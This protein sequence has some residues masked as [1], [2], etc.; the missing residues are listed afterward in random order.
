[1]SG[2]GSCTS[3][4]SKCQGGP[5]TA[6]LPTD[7]PLLVW[8]GECA[9]CRRWV[10]RLHAVAGDRIGFAP[11]QEAAHH[12]PHISQH[13]FESAIHLIEPDGTYTSG[14]EAMFATM[15]RLGLRTWPA[16]FYRTLAPFRAVSDT[17][18]RFTTRHRKAADIACRLALGRVEVP[19]TLLL[20]RRVFLRLLGLIYLIAFL[21]FGNQAM[22][23]IGSHGLRPADAL[24][25]QVAEGS[26]S[27]WNFP[28]LQWL[29]GD[30]VLWATWVIGAVAS[31]LLM[32]GIVPLLTSLVCWAMYLSLVTVG[33]VFLQYQWDNLLLECGL[34]AILWAPLTWRL[35]SPLARRPSRLVHWLLVL[36]LARLVFFGGLAKLQSGDPTWTDC[37]ALS[38]YFWTQPLP[39]WPAWI[40][41]S[42]PA[43]ILKLACVGI[44]ILEL[45]APLLLFL[46]RVPR[47]IGA[48]LIA[49]L[50]LGIAA[51]GNYGFFNWLA[52]VLCLSMLDDGVLLMLWPPAAR[53]RIAVG[54][55][56]APGLL[57]RWG[58]R[59]V[60]AVLLLLVLV[61]IREQV[62]VSRVGQPIASLQQAVR[63]WRPVGHYGLFATM[64]KTR[65]E[66]NIEWRDAEGT[67]HPVRFRW[68]PGPLHRVGG[69][70]QPGMPR[71]DWQLWFDA[72]TYEAAF[73]QGGLR[74]G[75][76]NLRITNR[77]VL[78][79]LLRQLMVLD[80][81]VVALLEESPSS[82]PTSLR[83][84]LDQ[85]RFTTTAE[86]AE[87]GDWWSKTRLFSSSP[88]VLQAAP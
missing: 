78:P 14:A 51:T 28:T 17:A 25:K 27:W 43:W 57:V 69:F 52:I 82:T 33:T 75:Q 8:D 11:L 59:G 74:P 76:F 5:P 40:A 53:A 6:A 23:L 34:L 67:W 54:L 39:W 49:G 12:Y 48:I 24:M 63:A 87:S 38:Y 60:S 31:C 4:G 13:A 26:A 21:S 3:C 41:A 30:T 37:T 50:M 2:C 18:Y 15:A 61:S 62:T 19:S 10:K 16:K 79:M 7:A 45:G 80:P 55:R 1:M 35:N 65:P 77:V 44:F 36:L 68:K 32:L 73:N 88:L 9:F 47:T 64:T 85:Y 70:C 29:G 46:P 20:T 58:R 42:L 56:H 71:L 72:L 86:R 84:H 81:P 66:I 22:G 83:W